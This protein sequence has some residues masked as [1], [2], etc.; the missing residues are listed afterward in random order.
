MEA[1]ALLR[2]WPTWS[3][4][5]AET[6]LASPAWRMPVVYDG[7]ETALCLADAPMDD[8]ILLGVKFDDEA[9]ILGI[10]DAAAFPDL[11]LLW[12]RR[13]ELDANLLLA[14]VE[15]E[16]GALFQMLEN[17]VRREF[18]VTGVV[19]AAPAGG[20]RTFRVNDVSFSLDLSSALTLSLGQ[21]GF[22]DATHESIRSMTRSAWADY[23]ACEVSEAEIAAL[24]VEDRVVLPEGTPSWSVEA[25][26]DGALHVRGRE[27]AQ[28]SFAQFADDDLPPVPPPTALELVRRDRTLA[29]GEI[30]RIGGLPC[31]RLTHL[32]S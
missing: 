7:E 19:D 5:N 4:A 9:H 14:L 30:S 23:G 22:L 24:A 16:C 18:S 1:N 15:K 31:F 27:A 12:K 32:H 6:V 3:H 13:A 8:E 25:P 17:A 2:E 10:R 21:I 20:R 29:E 26:A 11:H 28:L